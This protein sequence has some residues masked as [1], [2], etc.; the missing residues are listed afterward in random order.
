MPGN[1]LQHVLTSNVAGV[2]IGQA[3]YTIISNENGG[4]I[5]DAFLYRFDDTG[6][7][8]VVNAANRDKDWAHFQG[9]LPEFRDV[10]LEDR[11]VAVVMLSL[12]GPES[13]DIM[14]RVIQD[15]RLPEP[16][17]NY[18]SVIRIAGMEVMVGRTGYTGEPLCFELFVERA[19]GP[20]LWDLLVEKGAIPVGLGARD[21]LRLE[22][23][24]PLY[25][26]EFGQDPRRP[27][28]TDPGLPGRTDRGQHVSAQGELHRP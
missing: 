18:L 16:M 12:Q 9:I 17:R 24:L 15:G 7:L 6:Y 28:N 25:G 5:D 19:C 4:A 20:E 10:C 13:R 8:L 3:Q 1:F 11:T 22:A 23:G 21:T 14:G 26:H 2:D 27:G